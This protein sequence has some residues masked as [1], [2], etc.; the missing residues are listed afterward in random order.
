MTRQ[1]LP[2]GRHR[3]TEDDR[4]AVAAVLTSDWLTQGPAVGQFEGA[5]SDCIGAR[6]VVAC[7]S[8]TAALHLAMLALGIGPGDA[9]VTS[10]NTFLASASCARYVG[11]DVAFADIDAETGNLSYSSVERLIREDGAHCIKAILPV[12]FAGQPCDIVGIRNL[13]TS[14]GARVVEDACHALGAEYCDNG[15]W[16]RVGSCRHSDMTV[17]SFHPVKHV[18]M[19]EGGAISTDDPEMATRLRLFRNHGMRKD[20]FVD[21]ALATTPDG[22][23]NPWYYEM[24]ELGFNYRLTDIH[25]ALGQS[26]LMRLPQSLERRREI[27]ARYD[28]LIAKRFDPRAVRSLTKVTDVKHAYHL[29]VVQIDFDELEVDRA[30]VMT[31]LREAG[32]GTQVHYIPVP[33][34]PYY[35]KLYPSASEQIPE[36]LSYYRQALSLPMYPELTDRDVENV[37]ETLEQTLAASHVG[38]TH[39]G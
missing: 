20:G 9:V 27:A 23:V 38:A 33:L 6:E 36:T 11:A 34:Q 15:E 25:A 39:V 10:A 4:K 7:S 8:G 16:I 29:Y 24:H 35:R 30:T 1:F 18:A 26:Q 37:V 19:G 31:G 17:F 12:H 14:H 5:L 3:V 22:R 2:Y 32:V 13:A 28:E 21:R